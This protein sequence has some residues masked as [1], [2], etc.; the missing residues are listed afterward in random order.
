MSQNQGSSVFLFCRSSGNSLSVGEGIQDLILKKKNWVFDGVNRRKL[1]IF[2]T[3]IGITG[4]LVFGL[5][6]QFWYLV[7][8]GCETDENASL[9]KKI[10]LFSQGIPN[11]STF[12][13]L[14]FIDI[15]PHE[16]LRVCLSHTPKALNFKNGSNRPLQC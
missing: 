7:R 16:I 11:E 4:G 6:G 13:Y 10:F 12:E 3:N 15:F 14:G 8:L 5:G 9:P 1:R 2:L